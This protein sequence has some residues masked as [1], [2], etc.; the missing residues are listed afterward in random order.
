MDRFAKQVPERKGLRDNLTGMYYQNECHRLNGLW[1]VSE[2]WAIPG[3]LSPRPDG[4][5]THPLTGLRGRIGGAKASI[6]GCRQVMLHNT[7]V[8]ISLQRCWQ[9]RSDRLS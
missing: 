4:D 8:R 1:S 2:S 9:D 7:A 6:N 3:L 5:N